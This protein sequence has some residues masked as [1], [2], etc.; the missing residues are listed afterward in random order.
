MTKKELLKE[1]EKNVDYLRRN[2]P[3]DDIYM[4][5]EQTFMAA[6]YFLSKLT[7]HIDLEEE[8]NESEVFKK[9]ATN[10]LGLKMCQEANTD[11]SLDLDIDRLG[12]DD[13]DCN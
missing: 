6:L 8:A 5:C 13:E 10:I 9:W 12:E 3:P 4:F 11:I 2:I 1:F 7:D